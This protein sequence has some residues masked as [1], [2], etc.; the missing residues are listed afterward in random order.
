MI[1]PLVKKLADSGYKLAYGRGDNKWRLILFIISTFR[2]S[3]D[4]KL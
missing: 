4:K 2:R 3:K 1:R